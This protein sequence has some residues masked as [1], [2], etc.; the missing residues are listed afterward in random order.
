MKTKENNW[1]RYR[2]FY[3]T[4]QVETCANE[5]VYHQ[6]NQ[7]MMYSNLFY[8]QCLGCWSKDITAA[9]RY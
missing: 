5:T 4:A 1:I 9:C 6:A 3:Y 8:L 2:L 7:A